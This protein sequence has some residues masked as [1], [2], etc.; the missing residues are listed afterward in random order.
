M[1]TSIS[2]L[3]ERKGSTVF[4]VP[5]TITAAAAVQEMNRRKVGS[6]LIM[7]GDRLVGIFTERDV[8]SRVV[9]ADVDPKAHT[10]AEVMTRDVLTITPRA[11]VEEVMALFGQR[12]CRH[13]PV[14]EGARVVG[15]ISIGDISRW[16]ADV[17]R[18]EAE[19]LK[20]YITGGYSA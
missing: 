14:V 17:S 10:V 6:V 15:L 4:S 5:P 11:T 7:E 12:S 1:N 2:V 18:H 20:Q 8:L 9:A 19:Q 3:L 16:V 13:L